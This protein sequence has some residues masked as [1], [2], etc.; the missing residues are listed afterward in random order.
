MNL[1]DLTRNC[2]PFPLC[3]MRL[4][5]SKTLSLNFWCLNP[6]VCMSNI[7]S[8]AHTLI[9]ASGTLSPLGALAAE[10]DLEFPVRLEASHVVPVER[11][12]AASVARGPGGTRLCATFA[13][14]NAFVFQDDV[15]QLVLDACRQVPGGV[16]CFFPSYGLLDKMVSRWEVS[17]KWS[18][19]P[20]FLFSLATLITTANAVSFCKDDWSL[21]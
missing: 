17:W 11:V 5:E 18:S 15:G 10:L 13:N 9:L 2:F 16:L 8:V 14:Q 6:A 21:G 1:I 4:V 19:L 20:P 12:F 3:Q 7:A